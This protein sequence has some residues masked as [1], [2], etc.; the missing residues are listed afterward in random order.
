MFGSTAQAPRPV[1]TS[2]VSMLLAN[3]LTEDMLHQMLGTT[4]GLS[5]LVATTSPALMGIVH[6][7][8]ADSDTAS[9]A[10]SPAQGQQGQAA[11]E[12]ESS[13][14]YPVKLIGLDGVR[15][16]ALPPYLKR[17]YQ[18]DPAGGLHRPDRI[19]SC[20]AL[21]KAVPRTCVPPRTLCSSCTSGHDVWNATSGHAVMEKVRLA[22]LDH[23][24][25]LHRTMACMR[26]GTVHC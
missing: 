15:A 12:G 26:K 5:N 20:I 7:T 25:S 13:S 9:R 8:K 2:L 17:K 18:A 16:A 14:D 1:H 10:G 4:V 19:Q 21:P 23:V 24:P 6:R 22:G 11:G 3:E